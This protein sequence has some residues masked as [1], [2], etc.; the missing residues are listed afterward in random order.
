MSPTIA[1]IVDGR[2]A[3]ALTDGR[4][5]TER[6]A[7]E[8]G[9]P[10]VLVD[11]ALDHAT[12]PAWPW[13]PPTRPPPAIS[14]PRPGCSRRWA[15]ASRCWTTSPGMLVMR[16]VCMLA[17]EAADAVNQGV[18]SA[19]AVDIAM[20]L[21]V[22][23]PRGPLAWAEALGAAGGRRGAGQPRR[24]LRRGALPRVAA[25]AAPAV[26]RGRLT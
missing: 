20:R 10:L 18:A 16:T 23:Y 9:L 19:E 24:Q 21:G 4:T 13:P 11:L 15:S 6:M 22:G 14:R 5:A 26:L 3:L 1:I 8:G 25:A 2:V 12:A 7:S 17:N